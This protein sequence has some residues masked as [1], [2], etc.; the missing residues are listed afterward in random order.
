MNYPWGT[1][2]NGNIG[3][4][5]SGGQASSGNIMISSTSQSQ[6]AQQQISS[7]HVILQQQ[8]QS[9]QMSYHQLNQERIQ[10]NFEEMFNALCGFVLYEMGISKDKQGPYIQKCAIYMLTKMQEQG[11]V[12]EIRMLQMLKEYVP[13]VKFDSEMSDLLGD[14]E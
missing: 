5:I 1:S 8:M 10:K 14:K 3:T 13:T 11:N 7:Q 4:A 2:G 6:Q 12:S 9:Q